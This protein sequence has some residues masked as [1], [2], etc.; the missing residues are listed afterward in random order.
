MPTT[1][2]ASLNPQQ[3]GVAPAVAA[4]GL[5]GVPPAAW[6]KQKHSQ[7]CWLAIAAMIDCVVPPAKGRGQ[8]HIGNLSKAGVAHGAPTIADWC[9]PGLVNVNLQGTIP[10][11]L[12]ALETSRRLSSPTYGWSYNFDWAGIIAWVAVPGQFCPIIVQFKYAG[13]FSPHYI[14]ATGVQDDLLVVYD[15]A[16]YMEGSHRVELTEAELRHYRN[17]AVSDIFFV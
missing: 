13:T 8:C 2:P 7:W 5:G 1:M 9:D 11:A 17:G 12:D 14:M 10:V 15:P 16:E 3:M 6:T 4:S